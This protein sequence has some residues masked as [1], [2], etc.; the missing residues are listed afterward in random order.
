MHLDGAES[1]VTR[2][3]VKIIVILMACALK[4]ARVSVIS[5]GTAYHVKNHYVTASAMNNSVSAVKK[6]YVCVLSR[7]NLLG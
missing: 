7:M 4:V 3:F 5:A 6:E 2:K 1:L